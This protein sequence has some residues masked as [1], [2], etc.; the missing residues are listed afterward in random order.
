MRFTLPRSNSSDGIA[1][2]VPTS[3]TAN[4]S[5]QTL[6]LSLALPQLPVHQ[7]VAGTKLPH[8]TLQSPRLAQRADVLHLR[9][10]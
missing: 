10:G 1:I 5:Q 9:R 3:P 4:L 6:H 7:R 2:A 8:L